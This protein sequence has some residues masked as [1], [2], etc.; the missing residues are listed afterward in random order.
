MRRRAAIVLTGSLLLHGVA[1]AGGAWL[2]R[3]AHAREPAAE[4]K[5]ALA[6]ETFDISATLKEQPVATPE[7]A[8]PA[9]TAS[10]PA[11]VPRPRP[12][13]AA[14]GERSANAA[15][16]APAPLTYGALGDRSA[17]SLVVAVVRGFP[18]AASTDPIWR[19]V[20]FGDAGATTLEI[21]LEPDGT[22]ARWSL[23]AGASPA[24]RQAMVRTMALVGGRSFVARGAITKLRLASR[25]S[26]DAVR[27]GTDAVYAIHSEYEGDHGSAFFSLA[28]G[29]RVDVVITVDGS[30]R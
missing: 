16:P 7:V 4:P 15:A 19:T 11:E 20:P 25:V 1:G 24:L 23:G 8:A 10:E 12:R 17:T 3:R 21:E 6:G 28:S 14:R 27:D 2:A 5:P 26:P 30:Q 13:L 9:Q 29:R 18:Q 22:V